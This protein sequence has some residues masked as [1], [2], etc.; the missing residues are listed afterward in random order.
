MSMQE[1]IRLPLSRRFVFVLAL[2]VGGSTPACRGHANG[3]PK[4]PAEGVRDGLGRVV[5]IPAPPRRI[6]T[7]APNATDTI[8]ALGIGD[9]LVGVSDF[10][11]PPPEAKEVRRSMSGQAPES[12]RVPEAGARTT[13]VLGFQPMFCTRL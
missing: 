11:L 3:T 8:A 10:C 7:L 13:A 9:R 5:T 6:V 4:T 2:A 12:A 1:R